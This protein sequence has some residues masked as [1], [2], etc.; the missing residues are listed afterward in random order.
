MIHILINAILLIWQ[1]HKLANKLITLVNPVH[2][3]LLIL[4][5]FQFL[6]DIQDAHYQDWTNM[7]VLV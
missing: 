7:L 2:T 1:M 3:T 5:A 4:S 6:T